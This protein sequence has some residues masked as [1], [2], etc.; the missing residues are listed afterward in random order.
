MVC[1][2]CLFLKCYFVTW[3][4][5]GSSSLPGLVSHCGDWGLLWLVVCRLLNAVTSLFVERRL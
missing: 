4:C 5:V 3:G 2:L 1:E